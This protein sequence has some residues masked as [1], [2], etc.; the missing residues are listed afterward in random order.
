MRFGV[1]TSPFAGNDGT[2]LT[3]RHLKSGLDREVLGNV[4]IRVLPT[5]PPTPSRSRAGASCSWPC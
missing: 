3:S 4:A 1:N 2:Y 5:A